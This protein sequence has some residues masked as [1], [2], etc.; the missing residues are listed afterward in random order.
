[1]AVV[2]LVF[3]AVAVEAGLARLGL[4]S[5]VGALLGGGVLAVAA[6]FCGPLPGALRTPVSFAAHNSRLWFTQPFAGAGLAEL[7]AAYRAAPAAGG[8]TLVEAPFPARWDTTRS[9]LAAADAHRR[10]VVLATTEPVFAPPR[11]RFRTL[12]AAEPQA[13]LASE[14][15]VLLLHLRPDREEE[16]AARS[17]GLALR[18]HK[19]EQLAASASA[20][21][22]LARRLAESWGPA[23][24]RD[25]DFAVWDLG[26]VRGRRSGAALVR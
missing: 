9:L 23:D 18:P 5:A 10:R 17:A 7:P 11:T 8:E 15:D 16:S 25:L 14:G 21:A 20:A 26:R 12:V 3:L 22:E 1:M 6:F 24:Y 19:R 4:R 13:I 2:L